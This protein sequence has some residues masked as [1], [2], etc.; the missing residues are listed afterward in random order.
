MIKQL[1]LAFSTIYFL[2]SCN[3]LAS[4]A[5]AKESCKS[6]KGVISKGTVISIN[7]KDVQT[8]ILPKT[9]PGQWVLLDPYGYSAELI[10]ESGYTKNTIFYTKL[11]ETLP[12]GKYTMQFLSGDKKQHSVKIC[13][14]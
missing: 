10:T 4:S 8:V 11:G 5:Q 13:T 3:L 9:T 12:N 6:W 7:L 1:I 14:K 2:S